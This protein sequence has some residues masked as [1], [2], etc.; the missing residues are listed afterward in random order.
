M[1]AMRKRYDGSFPAIQR[2]AGL[3]QG[4]LPA[5]GT[6]KKQ[7]LTSKPRFLV[8]A[9]FFLNSID[10][11]FVLNL[12]ATVCRECPITAL[13]QTP[14]Y[15]YKQLRRELRIM[16]SSEPS[17]LAGMQYVRV[18]FCIILFRVVGAYHKIHQRRAYIT[19]A[20]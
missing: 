1:R 16:L 13:T 15:V 7:V 14:Q 17:I 20:V 5:T 19:A 9:G 12:R 3:L 8:E 11:V 2:Q 18:E 4:L 10:T 6:V